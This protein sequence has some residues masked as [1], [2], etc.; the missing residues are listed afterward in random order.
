MVGVPTLTFIDI[1]IF[2]IT[3]RSSLV[4][5]MYIDRCFYQDDVP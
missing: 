3:F 5:A 1:L 2:C 4:Y